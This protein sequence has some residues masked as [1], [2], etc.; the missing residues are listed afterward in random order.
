MRKQDVT[1]AMA[2]A[3][4]T[5][6]CMFPVVLC[7]YIIFE[8]DPAEDDLFELSKKLFS[9]DTG[10]YIRSLLVPIL[11]AITIFRS[12]D[13]IT[14]FGTALVALFVFAFIYCLVGFGMAHLESRNIYEDI[15]MIR[16]I[17][18]GFLETASLYVLVLLGIKQ[19]SMQSQR[20]I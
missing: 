2:I 12:D 15:E 8:I 10:E 6:Y 4:S 11:G 17:L 16:E 3:L 7:T 20:N 1:V 18:K 9:S 14:S 19:F 5:M 13:V